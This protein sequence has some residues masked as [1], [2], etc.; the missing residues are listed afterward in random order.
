[1]AAGHW[2]GGTPNVKRTEVMALGCHGQS[3]ELVVV[4]SLLLGAAHGGI[5]VLQ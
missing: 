2:T 5:G 1:M 3:V 4:S